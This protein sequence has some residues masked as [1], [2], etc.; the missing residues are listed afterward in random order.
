MHLWQSK[1]FWKN[2]IKKVASDRPA[3]LFA[4]QDWRIVLFIEM[5]IEPDCK[6]VFGKELNLWRRKTEEREVLA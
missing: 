6:T 1:P 4:L 3:F 5:F 2:I